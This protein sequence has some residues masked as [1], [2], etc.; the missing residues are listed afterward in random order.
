MGLEDIYADGINDT[1]QRRLRDPGPAPG[2]DS[3]ST[4]SF[5]ASGAKGP[6]SGALESAGSVADL[7]SGYGTAAAASG[8]SGQGMF[9]TG[10]DL[11]KKQIEEAN[12]ALLQGGFDV[13]A[14]NALRRKAD[15]FAPNP[16]TS[17][18]ADQIIHGLTRFAGKAIL[19]V[20][21]MGPVVGATALALDEGNTTTQRLRTEGVDTATAAG[22]GA[23]TGVLSGVGA[24]L[25]VG[26]STIAKTATLALLGGPASYVA[27]ESLSKKILADA[28]YNDQA[29]LH[30][31]ADPLGL[32]LSIVVPGAFGALHMRG[33]AKRANLQDVVQHIESGGKRFDKAGEILTSPKGAQGEMQ[34]MPGT[35]RDPGFG[36]V[37]AKDNSPDEL[38]R[39]GR[40]YLAAMQQRYPDADK[41]LAAY[42]AGP[43]AVDAAIKAHGDNWLAHM[44]DET[45]NYVAK[46]N[47]L[48][49][50]H[51][52]ATAVK[53]QQAV[54]AARVQ[55]LNEAITRSLPEHPEAYAEVMKASDEIA[56][57]RMPDVQEPPDQRSVVLNKAGEQF[58]DTRGGNERFH[59]TG[60]P[61]ESLSN[62]YALSGDS[63]NIYGQGF[64]TT[65]AADISAGY[66]KKGGKNAAL[67]SVDHSDVKLLD[68]EKPVAPD[69]ETILK[70]NMG[71]GF[72]TE[73]AETGKPLTTLREIY[74][75]FRAESKNNGMSRDD[76]QEVFDGIR[77]KLEEQGYRGFEHQ[78]GSA[79][80]NRAHSV[81]IFWNPEQDVKITPAKI[82]D[83]Q[84]RQ[85]PVPRSEAANT[86][87][88]PDSVSI[89]GDKPM[90]AVKAEVPKTES[91]VE[92]KTPEAQRVETLAK[93]QPD[94][95]VRLPGS[96]ET[97]TLTQAM[98]QAKAEFEFDSGEVGLYQAALDCALSF[99]A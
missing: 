56:A 64:Y 42:N 28:G 68:M 83:Y 85:S 15:E 32:A 81:K 94:M 73:N 95:K 2:V 98:E 13:K 21:T 59:G 61:I 41:A 58:Y 5:L 1:I 91:G 84:P 47:N 69:I 33:V 90:E 6:V 24:V 80:G 10:T 4:W 3:F 50:D 8:G 60:K 99:G 27:Q 20:A 66:M 11:E 49:G 48:I 86:L 44:P 9:S 16:E 40:D 88:P 78:G 63:R 67:Y 29:S 19:D 35:A 46:A 37:P 96:E 31:P 77:Y 52:T 53:D 87:P 75:E 92:A 51:I 82:G 97:V 36:V 43:G 45:K 23:V 12:K 38:A 54:D 26:G 17:T 34:V 39:V 62:E 55:V 7:L 74:D 25:P 70:N 89:A 57:G 22:V 72:P 65:D 30:N 14:G 76:V 93:E 71:D 79:T 18:K